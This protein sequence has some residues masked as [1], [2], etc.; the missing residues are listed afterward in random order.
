MKITVGR[1]NMKWAA[2]VCS[3]VVN[4]KSPREELRCVRIEARS[5][6]AFVQATNLAEWLT[7][8]LGG[9]ATEREGF[10]GVNLAE[11]KA[12]VKDA[13]R[14]SSSRSEAMT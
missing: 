11:L 9:V 14:R 7:I 10:C 13:R 3:E 6:K 4:L 1:E 5:G 2:E 12:F 8:P